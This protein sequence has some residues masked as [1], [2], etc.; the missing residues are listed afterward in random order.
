MDF[1]ERDLESI[2]FDAPANEL[3][4]R[5]LDSYFSDSHTYKQLT[6]GNYGI[7]DIVQFRRQSII[8]YDQPIP[9]VSPYLEFNIIELKKNII[10]FDTFLQAIGYSKGLL[11]F[12]ESRISFETISEI[13]ITLIGKKVDTS[14][15]VFL[16]DII[17]GNDFNLRLYT[18]EYCFDGIRFIEHYDYSLQGTKFNK[19]LPYS[20]YKNT[21]IDNSKKSLINDIRF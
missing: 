18:Y 15:F 17:N 9:Y 7:A 8:K 3:Q 4:A 16:P 10:T 1:L 2:I 21:K 14:N 13:N 19:K 12:V 20:K 5:G 6:I 11:K